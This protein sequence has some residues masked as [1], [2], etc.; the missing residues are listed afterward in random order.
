MPTETNPF[1][2]ADERNAKG[3]CPECGEPVPDAAAATHAEMHWPGNVPPFKLS[4]EAARRK[5]MLLARAAAS[6][7][8]R[9]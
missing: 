2:F 1:A 5:A 6:R 8:A 9:S 7:G 4:D 3:L